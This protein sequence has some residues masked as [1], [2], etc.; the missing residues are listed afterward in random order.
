MAGATATFT[1]GGAAVTLDGALAGDRFHQYD[2]RERDGDDRHR[3]PQRRHLE[4]HQPGRHHRQLQSGHRRADPERHREPGQLPDGA[5]FYHVQLQPEQRV[6]RPMAVATTRPTISW[7]VNDGV[8]SSTLVT[9]NIMKPVSVATFIADETSLNS[10]PG[11]FG[12]SCTRPPMSW[13]IWAALTADA[14]HIASITATGGPVIVG[15]ALF[16]A[17]EA[18]LNKIV[19]GFK[20]GG[21]ASVLSG[22]LD[23][24]V[25]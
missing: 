18:A 13:P 15:N 10:I 23:G 4:L 1:G 20:I 25:G 8:A 21:Q 9:S 6:T 3:V 22:Q 2:A 11:G 17:D 24:L 12:I 5:E 16:V 19:G 7:V 14:S